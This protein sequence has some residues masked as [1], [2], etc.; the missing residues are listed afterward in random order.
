MIRRRVA[1]YFKDPQSK[2]EPVREWL[3]TLKDR[4]AQAAIY[5]RIARA[6]T[7]NFGDHKSVGEGVMEMRIPHGPRY[8]LYYAFDGQDVILLLMGGDKS[9]RS[10]DIRKAKE[11]W[12][13]HKAKSKRD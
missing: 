6:E 8:R 2:T 13:N 5:V 9:T 4:I 10:K 3:E 12:A 11:F 1:I 7:G